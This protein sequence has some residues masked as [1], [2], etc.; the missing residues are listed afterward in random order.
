MSLA[1]VNTFRSAARPFDK[2]KP[3]SCAKKIGRLRTTG[4]WAIL[5]GVLTVSAS[6]GFVCFPQPTPNTSKRTTTDVV[7]FF[8]LASG[9]AVPNQEL[10]ERVDDRLNRECGSACS[11]CTKRQ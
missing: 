1:L 9:L 4:A 3:R 11:S 5:I 2:N 6:E 7:M 8:M 10:R